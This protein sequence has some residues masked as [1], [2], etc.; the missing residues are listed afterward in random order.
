[1]IRH[2]KPT[3]NFGHIVNG[4]SMEFSRDFSESGWVADGVKDGKAISWYDEV[5]LSSNKYGFRSDDFIEKG[6]H[7]GKH[8]LFAGCSVTWGDGLNREET[9]PRMVYEELSK[10]DKLSGYF[11]IGFPGM[12]I[13]QEIFWMFKYFKKFGN[14]DAIFFL[15]PNVGRFISVNAKTHAYKGVG[16]S[17]INAQIEEDYPGTLKLIRYMTYEI[18]GM[19]EDYCKEN[20]IALIS[21]SW[22][23]GENEIINDGAIGSTTLLLGRGEFESFFNMDRLLG[24][25]RVEFMY[26]YVDKNPGATIR[27]RDGDHP[28]TAEQAFYA[29]AMLY[30]YRELLDENIRV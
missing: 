28:G 27:S 1:M 20:G 4:N 24:V 21:S 8:I 14:P 25:N 23:G 18:Y 15:M 2:E 11:S 30:K 29:K 22:A 19:L 5:D 16:S 6:L 3:F 10:D 12:S 26:D 7:Q 13:I 17:I 9:W